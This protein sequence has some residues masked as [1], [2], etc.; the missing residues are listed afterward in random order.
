[1]SV[2]LRWGDEKRIKAYISKEGGNILDARFAMFG[3]EPNCRRVDRPYQ[4]RF[5]DRNCHEH[6]AMFL[7]ATEKGPSIVHDEIVRV[8]E[9]WDFQKGRSVPVKPGS[10]GP[11][12]A[13]DGFGG[14][15][16]MRMRYQPKNKADKAK[17]GSTQAA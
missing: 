17:A 15:L 3:A 11:Q 2:L 10:K 7:A 9:H 6:E 8:A 4:V 1:M 12:S 14:Y 5:L 16:A 13:A